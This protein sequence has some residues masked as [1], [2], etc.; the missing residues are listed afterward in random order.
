MF[1]R[2]VLRFPEHIQELKIMPSLCI[3]RRQSCRSEVLI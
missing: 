1:C 2:C 3:S